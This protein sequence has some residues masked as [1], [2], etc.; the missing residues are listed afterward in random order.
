[1]GS[2][3]WRYFLE[4]APQEAVRHFHIVRRFECSPFLGVKCHG[5]GVWGTFIGVFFLFVHLRFFFILIGLF[6]RFCRHSWLP[7]HFLSLLVFDL[8]WLLRW[9]GVLVVAVLLG[10][11]FGWQCGFRIFSVQKHWLRRILLLLLLLLLWLWLSLPSWLCLL[12]AS[13]LWLQERDNLIVRDV[14]RSRASKEN[15]RHV[16]R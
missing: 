14:G 5:L 12:L 16:S 7:S 3:S 2:R 11:S 4:V 13:R 6:F 1:M 15:R 8:S 9:T 10:G